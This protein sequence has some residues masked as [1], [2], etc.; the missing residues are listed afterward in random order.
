[1]ETLSQIDKPIEYPEKV[2]DDKMH[3]TIVLGHPGA[4]K[5]S[6]VKYI[7][8]QHKRYIASIDEAV[9]WAIQ[10][11]TDGGKKAK[12]YLDQRNIEREKYNE[13]REKLKKKAG[14][15]APELDAKWGPINES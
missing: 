4:G 8:S 14:K 6:A 1:M 9:D 5:T 7:A 3:H 2:A 11:N 10:N 12:E 13:E 15:K